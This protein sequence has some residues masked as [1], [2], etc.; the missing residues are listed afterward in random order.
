MPAQQVEISLRIPQVKEALKDDSGYPINNNDMR[1]IRSIN[2]ES[3][4]KPGDSIQ[5]STRGPQPFLGTVMQTRWD[6]G[7]EMFVVACRY[8]LKSISMPVYLA[9]MGDPDWTRKPLLQM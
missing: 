6:D 7:K 2:V 9:L 3:L 4:P 5:L 1:F 8:S